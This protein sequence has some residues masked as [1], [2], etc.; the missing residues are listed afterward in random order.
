MTR[1]VK[2][3]ICINL[4]LLTLAGCTSVK[5]P[6]LVYQPTEWKTD[7]KYI[8]L[9]DGYILNDGY[10]YDIIETEDGYDLVLHF[11]EEVE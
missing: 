1:L 9:Q 6:R 2:I 8:P 3:I 5:F 11:V 7:N 4:L 10:R